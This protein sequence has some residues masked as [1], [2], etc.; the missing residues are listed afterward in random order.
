MH[1]K[2]WSKQK[3]LDYYRAE[4]PA[5]DVDSENEINRYITWPG[6]ALAYKVGQ[7]KFRELREYSKNQLGEAF[8]VRE[9]H[10]EVL[11]H[12]ALP[13]DVLEKSVRTWVAQKKVKARH[14]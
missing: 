3:A 5:P 8:D 6:Q 2:G 4:M 11:R 7:L 13:L 9:F 10:D 14:T 12:G 1:F